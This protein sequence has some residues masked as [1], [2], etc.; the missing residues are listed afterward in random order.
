MRLADDRFRSPTNVM[1]PETVRLSL[2]RRKHPLHGAHAEAMVAWAIAMLEAGEDGPN[3]RL[4]T[5]AESMDPRAVERTFQEAVRETGREVTFAGDR[6]IDRTLARAYE[7]GVVSLEELKSF[8][9]W[10]H[11]ETVGLSDEFGWRSLEEDLYCLRK[12]GSGDWPISCELDPDA[13]VKDVRSEILRV[14]REWGLLD[15]V[16][17]GSSLES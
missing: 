8:I 14:F 7:S 6:G 4:L 2:L 10:A 12:F 11:L 16:D 17:E 3:L 15:E 5:A 13:A 1:E 9:D